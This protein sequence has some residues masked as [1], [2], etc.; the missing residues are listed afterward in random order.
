MFYPGKKKCH[1]RENDT[2][3]PGVDEHG[4]KKRMNKRVNKSLIFQ[5]TDK[6]IGAY[7]K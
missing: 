2:N 3:D 4:T 7:N 6:R 1:G 5:I